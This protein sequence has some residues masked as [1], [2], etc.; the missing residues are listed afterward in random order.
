MKIIRLISRLFVGIVFIFSGFVK[1][2]DPVGTQIKL[3]DYFNAFGMGFM[4]PFTLPLSYFLCS[5]EFVT[6]IMLLW[7]IRM[8]LF[9]YIVLIIEG[10]FL[11]FTLILAIYNPVSDCGCFG[12]A[13]KLTNWETFYK[14]VILM[15]FVLIIFFQRE[16]FK[17]QYRLVTEWIIV[18]GV[19]I[20]FIFFCHFNY[21]HLPLF[22]FRPYKIGTYL[23]DN[24]AIPEGAKVDKYKTIFYYKDLRSGKIKE[25]DET[26]YPWQDTINW[27][28]ESYKANLIEKGYEPPIHDFSITSM[29]GYD[30]TDSILNFKGYT[31]LLIS[32]HIEKSN[33]DAFVEASKLAAITSKD[34]NFKFYCITASSQNDIIKLK[35]KKNL[36]YSFASCDATPLKTIIRSNPGLVLL[37]EGTVIA[38]WHYNNLPEIDKINNH[39]L[40][41][42]ITTYRNERMLIYSLLSITALIII[43]LSFK[44][45]SDL[46]CKNNQ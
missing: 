44:N 11:L 25:F 20:S 29:E 45:I 37:K 2:V 24:M 3:E 41:E 28:F 33:K 30:L 16:K 34:T 9:A 6:G 46:F 13:W 18:S 15:I 26:N 43:I 32:P 35:D 40:S 12:D 27:K 31:F 4:D 23:R 36:N 38:N 21:T 39:Y 19:F 42:V 1:G 10:F 14:N 17:E 8:Y 22:D 5:I 7:G